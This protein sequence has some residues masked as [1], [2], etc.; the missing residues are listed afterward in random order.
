M[1]AVSAEAVAALVRA[2]CATD[3][4][5]LAVLWCATAHS[6]AEFASDVE[7]A[8]QACPAVVIV[9]KGFRFDDPNSVLDDLVL[10]LDDAREAVLERLSR[11]GVHRLRGVVL[12]SRSALAVPQLSSPSVLPDWVPGLGGTTIEVRL[13]DA[14]WTA[15]VALNDDALDCS[16]LSSALFEFD[17]AAVTQLAAVASAVPAAGESFFDR[18]RRDGDVS[19]ASFCEIALQTLDD[20]SS[21]NG[22]RPSAKLGATVVPRL[23]SLA[24]AE[25][26][27]RHR[28]IARSLLSAFGLQDLEMFPPEPFVSVLGRPTTPLESRGERYI[29]GVIN[30]VVAGC[31]LTTA[32]AHADDYPRYPHALLHTLS[33]NLQSSLRGAVDILSCQGGG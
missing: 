19:L 12:V 31:Q 11:I 27:N 23:W 3:S 13:E 26:A 8:L 4:R 30:G 1:S 24:Q 7:D 29:L 5:E 32:A 16:G 9:V 15:G 6:R 22:Y 21:P 2:R 14:T 25:A 18:I 17:V 33:V 10:L 28:R 20:V